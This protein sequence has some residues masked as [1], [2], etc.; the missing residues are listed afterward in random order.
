MI[1][2]CFLKEPVV[3]VHCKAGKGRTGLV[4]VCFMLYIELF[5]TV[6]EAIDHYDRLRTPG[7]KGLSIPSQMR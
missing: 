5:E 2:D 1:E 3:A 4:I 7:A 6:E